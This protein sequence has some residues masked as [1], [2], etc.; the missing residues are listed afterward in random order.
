[1]SSISPG[2]FSLSFYL[3]TI[4]VV[5]RPTFWLGSVLL[6]MGLPK[7]ELVIWV[8]VVLVSILVHELGHALAY[9][10]FRAGSAIE[11]HAFGG[12][13]YGDRDVGRWPG[14]LVSL[15][16]P[17]AGF[18]FGG[19]A[20]GA[21]A[22]W[23]DLPRPAIAALWHLKWVNF[24]WG[25]MNLLPVLPLDG[26]HVLEG[27]LG[28]RHQARIPLIAG[29]VAGLVAVGAAHYEFAYM[30][31]LFGY[32][33]FRNLQAWRSAR[34]RPARPQA[35]A[36]ENAARLQQGWD[37]LH[38]GNER[39]AAR[40]GKQ[41]LDESRRNEE[42]AK[43]LDLLAWAAL[44]EGATTHALAYL[45]QVEPPES[46]R[47]LTWALA[48]DE[49]GASAQA[50]PYSLQA[51]SAE[52]SDTSASLAARLLISQGRHDEAARILT[53]F[54]WRNPSAADSIAAL[55]VQARAAS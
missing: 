11:L 49:D 43:A 29:V 5:I 19:I 54:P 30:A 23:E 14:V 28:P 10:F 40:F 22:L 44:A 4:P 21:E 52:P 26:G 33:A 41:V 36:S 7:H 8:A 35:S 25:L 38:A 39:E 15:A 31:L 3:G 55:L 17:M 27:V 46:A 37:A 24:F 9:R 20:L 47:A 1:M 32:L 13:C 51:L 50:L 12:R 18:L 42:R 48:L 6:G 53:E 16:G 45:R 34:P 2:P